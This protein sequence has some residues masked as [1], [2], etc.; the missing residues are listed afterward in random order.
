MK[1]IED[2]IGAGYAS[3][4]T[5]V[6][7]NAI[8]NTHKRVFPAYGGGVRAN[9]TPEQAVLRQERE[10]EA[11]KMVKQGVVIAEKQK[12][13]EA[14]GGKVT[15]GESGDPVCVWFN[16][17]RVGKYE[18]Q[19]PL[20]MLSEELLAAQYVPNEEVVKKFNPEFK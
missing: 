18:Q 8:F 17:D 6:V 13:C 4:R 14:L 7:I 10:R 16:Y 9:E 19:L 2:L 3:N 5:A 15:A 12:I 11:R 20:P 1:M